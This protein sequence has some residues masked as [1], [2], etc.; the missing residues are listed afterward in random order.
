MIGLG[1]T[2]TIYELIAN[3]VKQETK[4]YKHYIG[5]VM[6][7]QDELNV[8]RVLVAVPDLAW[9]TQD[10]AAWAYPRQLNALKIP[11]IGQWVEIYFLNGDKTKP[12]YLGNTPEI[13]KQIPAAY[14][15]D[16]KE[17]VLYQN[18]ETE[19]KIIY[20]ETDDELKIGEASESFVKGD[21]FKAD[22][23][24][25]LTGAWASL[26]AGAPGQNAAILTAL[27]ASA[28]TFSA[29]LANM[30]SLKIKGE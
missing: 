9:T 16:T 4:Y 29:A 28:A 27:Q 19:Q 25:F 6:D 22:L 14:I 15:G 7:N 2:R 30:L 13:K 23:N 11:K 1:N 5:E 18:P 12:V 24:T 10:K 26:P 17:Q 21:T 8:G 3:I 20:N